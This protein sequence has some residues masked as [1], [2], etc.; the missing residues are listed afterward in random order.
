MNETPTSVQSEEGVDPLE[1]SKAEM[2]RLLSTGNVDRAIEILTEL[3]PADA[4]DALETLDDEVLSALLT[5][6]Q[7]GAAAEVLSEIEAERRF[8]VAERMPAGTLADI[9]DVMAPDEAADFLQWVDPGK[10]AALIGRME[11]EEASDVAELLDFPEDSAGRRMSQDFVAVAESLTAEEVI[12]KLREVPEDVELVYYVYVLGGSEQL[13]GV[14][15]LRRLITARPTAHVSSLMKTDLES[16]RP[17]DPLES[18]SELIERYN[19]IALPVTDDLGRMLGIIT[20]DDVLESIEEEAEED[21]LRFAGSISEDDGGS[22]G[23]LSG[24]RKRLPWLGIASVVE[25]ALAY[26]L[27]RPLPRDLLLVTVAYIPLLL[28]TGGN[29]AVQAAA[30]VL[31][32]LSSPRTETWSPW[33]QARKELEA[34]FILAL[35]SAALTFPLVWI[36]GS[37]VGLAAIVAPAVAITVIFGAGLGAS[38]PIILHR[39]KFDPAIA[40]GPLIG[41]A[42]DIVSLFVYVTLALVF[43][44]SIV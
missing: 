22:R 34:G 18:A 30:R 32:R 42:M 38:L 3:H 24:I 8:Q 44:R 40:S 19:L 27:L 7:P 41:S 2:E 5:V 43:Q 1:S 20:V 31:V 12:Q 21:V 13:K 39:L 4:A 35:I 33:L 29:A 23:S 9:L 36:L 16:V 37:G 26:A 15:S 25:L 10:R 17:T 11:R 6:W 28:L 14:V